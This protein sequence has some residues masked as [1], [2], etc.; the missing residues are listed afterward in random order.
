VRTGSWDLGQHDINSRWTIAQIYRWYKILSP[1]IEL[2]VT[3]VALDSQNAILY[4]GVQQNFRVW[5]IALL[6]YVARV[7]LVTK[8][9][10]KREE[11]EGRYYI[12]SQE[13]LYQTDQF[14]RFVWFGVWRGVMVFQVVNL[15][16]CVLM[17]LLLKP[18]T[19]VEE[20]WQYGQVKNLPKDDTVKTAAEWENEW[21]RQ[22]DGMGRLSN[23]EHVDT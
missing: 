10:L 13:D 4:V 7:E 23:T 19:W 2:A 21:R 12:E 22:M 1:R 15:I 17:A 8:L 16:V 6:G 5:P 11:G 14:A 3:S 20:R 9:G 18:V